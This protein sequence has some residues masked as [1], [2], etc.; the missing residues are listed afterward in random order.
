MYGNIST[1]NYGV[2]LLV[3]NKFKS[4]EEHFSNI[5]LCGVVKKNSRLGLLK[6]KLS[7]T[8]EKILVFQQI[9]FSGMQVIQVGFKS[10]ISFNY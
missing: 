9:F 1:I 2:S 7:S 6:E 10:K 3:G 4:F 8:R 5:Q